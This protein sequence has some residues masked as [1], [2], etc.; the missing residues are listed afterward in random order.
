MKIENLINAL[1]PITGGIYLFL[2]AKGIVPKNPKDPVKM[3]LWRKKFGK[4]SMGLAPFLV[5]FGLLHL[6]G[7]FNR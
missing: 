6:F 1:I 2:M 4:L 5:L 3:E 7:V